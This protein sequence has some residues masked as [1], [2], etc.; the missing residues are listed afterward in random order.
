MDGWI[1]C[2]DAWMHGCMDAWMHGLIDWL[3]D[4]LLLIDWLIDWLSTLLARAA[5]HSCFPEAQ[6]MAAA[7]SAEG[8]LAMQCGS[9]NSYAKSQGLHS[10]YYSDLLFCCLF[11]QYRLLLGESWYKS[12]RLEAAVEHVHWPSAEAC[13]WSS[14][15]SSHPGTEAEK[16]TAAGAGD[17]KV[18]QTFDIFEI[19]IM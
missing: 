17:V 14:A 7:E 12:V 8:L 19:Y 3:I 15:R 16:S 2:M 9:R 13:R 1:G 6:V 11:L 10:T 18:D 4:L 5:T